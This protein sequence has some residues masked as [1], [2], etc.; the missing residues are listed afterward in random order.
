M[1]EVTFKKGDKV[2]V[3]AGIKTPTHAWG[4]VKPGD[5]GTVSFVGARGM[6]LVDFQKQ[7]GWTAEMSE[8][9]LVNDSRITQQGG[10]VT[11]LG[12]SITGQG[13]H[14]TSLIP[15]VAKPK[16][17]S[18]EKVLGYAVMKKDKLH[19][20]VTDRDI[21]RDIKA[22]LGGKLAGATIVVLTAGKEIR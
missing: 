4:R 6:M 16:R 1:S 18:P 20:I 10:Q 12:Q 8:M 7:S 3:Q 5:V 9:E 19:K 21:A 13:T 2:C 14:V 11:P 17:K 15:T 22:R